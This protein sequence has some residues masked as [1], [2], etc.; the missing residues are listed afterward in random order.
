MVGG[1]PWNCCR[2]DIWLLDRGFVLLGS[3]CHTLPWQLQ[4]NGSCL[5]GSRG[6]PLR[7]KLK[8]LSRC[9]ARRSAIGPG[10]GRP[11]QLLGFVWRVRRL[12]VPE[13]HNPAACGIGRRVQAGETNSITTIV[14]TTTSSTTT[15]SSSSH[16]RRA[17]APKLGKG[18]ECG[19]LAEPEPSLSQG[20]RPPASFISPLSSHLPARRWER[21]WATR[22]L[23]RGGRNHQLP[24]RRPPP[25]QLS[26]TPASLTK[27]MH[28][29]HMDPSSPPQ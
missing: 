22:V 26:E 4:A 9:L 17:A 21:K 3:L 19:T 13:L 11:S 10:S 15:G 24:R 6:C 2:A 27:K 7:P 16:C 5:S 23:G 14:T 20:L 8:G 29:N 1:K 12:L 18:F 28:P 25:P